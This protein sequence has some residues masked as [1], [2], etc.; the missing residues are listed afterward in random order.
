MNYKAFLIEAG[1]RMLH[2]GF[3]VGTWGNIS[4][5]DPETGYVYLTPSGMP[6]DTLT[7]DD[8]VVMDLDANRI[9]GE[10]RPTIE[11][12]MHLGIMKNR[13][14]SV[15]KMVLIAMLAAI[16]YLIVS[17]IRI[18]VV[19]FLKYEPKDVIITIGGFLLGPMA[20]FIISLVVSLV[21]MVTV[22]GTGP[23]G[24]LMNLLSTCSFA[25]VAA[26][27]YK[28]RH[29]LWGAVVG[30]L[31][32]TVA[33]VVIML[34]WNWL[35]TPLYMGTPREVVEG[36]LLPVFLPFNLLKAG[37]NSAFVLGLYKPL[38][39]AL[40]KTRLLPRGSHPRRKAKPSIYIL[41][42]ALLATCVLVLL[43]LQG[44]I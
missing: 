21:E 9:E 30:L 35:I 14:E 44:K 2:S 29:N 22:S 16:S 43:V 38:T 20:S 23:I 4:V 26:L 31:A 39:T 41:A 42:A 37:F 27:I 40:Q 36:M 7:E 34:L 5:R 17:Y 10:R 19:L 6:Y 18:P 13:P 12:M 3:T 1:K 28:K 25:C 15:R 33:M 32:G 8:I 11:Y 24:C